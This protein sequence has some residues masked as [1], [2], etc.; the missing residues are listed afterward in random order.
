MAVRPVC[1]DHPNTFLRAMFLRVAEPHFERGQIRREFLWM[2]D[3]A[4]KS[5]LL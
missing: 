4:G 1:S 2:G 5:R 3:V